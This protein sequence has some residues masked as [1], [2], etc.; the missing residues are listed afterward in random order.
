MHPGVNSLAPRFSG[1]SGGAIASIQ[2]VGFVPGSAVR[3][4]APFASPPSSVAAAV[5][6]VTAT[7]EFTIPRSP[8]PGDGSG[9]ACVTVISNGIE[10]ECLQLTYVVPGKPVLTFT[11]LGCDGGS[12][13]TEALAV[14]GTPTHV[15]VLLTAS[16]NAFRNAAGNWVAS[17]TVTTPQ[18][19]EV[20]GS[21]P[22]AAQR[23]LS[24]AD[25]DAD[26]SQSLHSSMS[27]LEY[28]THRHRSSLAGFCRRP[29]QAGSPP[30]VFGTGVCES[31]RHLGKDPLA[32]RP[33]VEG[34]HSSNNAAPEWFRGPG[35]CLGPPA[36]LRSCQPLR[37]S[38]RRRRQT[39]LVYRRRAQRRG[40]GT[41][42]VGNH[43]AEGPLAGQLPLAAGAGPASE[44]RIMHLTSLGKATAWE[45][46][47]DIRMDAHS[48]SLI[49][50]VNESGVYALARIAAAYRPKFTHS[51]FP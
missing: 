7:I 38:Q 44:F 31:Y 20:M 15:Q 2:G 50:K 13:F 33:Y 17:L 4:D 23:G 35:Y 45:E 42:C 29:A 47:A 34:P 49:G 28:P 46:V 36:V 48:R 37:G 51:Q 30:A 22:L 24:D 32:G 40:G 12:L 6:S 39:S 16:Y 3:V 8:L 5:T 21:G 9:K 43:Q 1:T 41:P 19:V 18:S 10:S 11:W 14:D 27:G 25:R 26:L